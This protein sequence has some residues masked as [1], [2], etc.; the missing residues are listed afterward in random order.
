MVAREVDTRT[1]LPVLSVRAGARPDGPVTLADEVTVGLREPIAS[2]GAGDEIVSRVWTLDV[3]R[4]PVE[5]VREAPQAAPQISVLVSTYERGELLRSCLE[6]FAD[7]TID[8]EDFE[9]VVVDD[10]SAHSVVDELVHEFGDRLQIVGIRIGHAGR[11]AAKNHAVLLARA[12]IVLF[13][14]DDD[15]AMP[16]YLERHLAG[17]AAKPDESVAILGHTDWAPELEISPLMHFVTDV[18]RLMFSYGSLS[19]GQELDW[20]GFWEGRISCKRA[21]L[22]RHALHD[23]RLDYSIDIEMGWRLMPHGLRVRYDAA[24]TSVMARPLDFEGFCSR[25]QAKGKAMAVIAALHRGAG[26]ADQL[27]LEQTVA[28]FEDHRFDEETLRRQVAALEG[29]A[30]RG[31][32]D[33]IELDELHDSYR[34]MFRLLHAKGVAE[35]T[36]GVYAMS[37]E[38][39][40]A[41]PF[42]IDPPLVHDGTPPDVPSEP[43]L[44]VTLPVWSRS[45]ELAE[46]AKGTIERIWEVARVP[47]E[48]VAVDNGSDYEIPLAAKVYRYPENK[49]VSIGWNTGIRLATAPV[50]VV[51]NSDCR[52]EP[53]WDEALLEAATDGRRVAFSVHRSL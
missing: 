5:W 36:G 27:N 43:V 50:V 20:K 30:A 10:G 1:P 32:A 16:D 18:D 33:E 13:F 35:A 14:D 47:T 7:Q 15:R 41:Q 48:V 37:R 26:I 53:G 34:E 45:P 40:T 9:V 24:A 6:S 25:T 21:P 29:A 52:V 44:T 23:Q 2:D 4:R 19:D 51:M 49:G 39:T 22:L 28:Y 42:P 12:P 38:P 31:D 8:R 11:S 3:D 17:H 46:M